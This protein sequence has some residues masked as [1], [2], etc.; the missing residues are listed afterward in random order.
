MSVLLTSINED[1]MTNTEDVKYVGGKLERQKEDVS[2]L[3]F[4]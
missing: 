3:Y 4:V 1:I 2:E